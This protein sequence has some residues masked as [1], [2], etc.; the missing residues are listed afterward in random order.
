M[1][2]LRQG[3]RPRRRSPEP[4]GQEGD[5]SGGEHVS[6]PRWEG[7]GGATQTGGVQWEPGHGRGLPRLTRCRRKGKDGA[8]A[9]VTREGQVTGVTKGRRMQKGE[10]QACG[11][12]EGAVQRALAS[13]P[14]QCL[15]CFSSFPSVGSHPGPLCQVVPQPLPNHR[16][17]CLSC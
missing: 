17:T 6:F 1:K 4:W 8:A 7:E 12:A 10:G 9:Y 15:R 13:V 11:D 16:V 5:S 14:P 3:R 2:A